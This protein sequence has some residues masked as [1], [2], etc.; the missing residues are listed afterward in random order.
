MKIKSSLFFNII[1]KINISSNKI[2]TQGNEKM[3][4]FFNKNK[5]NKLI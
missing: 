3:N 5:L 1:K 4:K 2:N